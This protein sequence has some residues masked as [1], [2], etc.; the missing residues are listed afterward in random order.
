MTMILNCF[1]RKKVKTPIIEKL[2]L[3]KDASF[4]CLPFKKTIMGL[5]NP[6]LV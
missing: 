1:Y 2:A 4:Y 3:K 6:I 5:K